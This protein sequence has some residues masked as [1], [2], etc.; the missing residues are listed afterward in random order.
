M[1]EEKSISDY[2]K[3]LAKIDKGRK[4]ARLQDYTSMLILAI[5]EEVGEMARAYL[6]KKGRKPRDKRAQT[7]ETYKQE[8]GDII[9]AIMKLANLRD[10]D[11]DKQIKYSLK[12]IKQRHP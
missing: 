4:G 12:K 5:V 1:K 9:L 2:Q 11:L 3:E 8:L 10:I 6:T 7:D